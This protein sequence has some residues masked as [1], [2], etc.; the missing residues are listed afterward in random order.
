MQ[1]VTYQFYR[2]T[3]DAVQLLVHE[4]A[5]YQ[6]GQVVGLPAEQGHTT[7]ARVTAVRHSRKQPL[8]LVSLTLLTPQQ[9]DPTQ[10]TGQLVSPAGLL[11]IIHQ[12]LGR[13]HAPLTFHT[14]GGPLTTDARR[15][16]PLTWL[17]HRDS[18]AV[19]TLLPGLVATFSPYQRIIIIDPTGLYPRVDGCQT[20][21]LGPD[22]PLDLNQ[23]GWPRFTQAMAQCLP[24]TLDG[25]TL[26]YLLDGASEPGFL[27]FS[28][29]IRPLDDTAEASPGNQR[30]IQQALAQV[31]QLGLFADYP[32]QV[33]H[34]AQITHP[35][36]LQLGHLPQPW[37]SLALQ[38]VWHMLQHCPASV[39]LWIEPQRFMPDAGL[40][41]PQHTVL[42]ASA[43][44]IDGAVNQLT[45]HYGQWLLQGQVTAGF[46]VK[47]S[48]TSALP[49][50]DTRWIEPPGIQSA[51]TLTGPS[52][53]AID[54]PADDAGGQD[55]FVTPSPETPPAADNTP[56]PHPP[57][58]GEPDETYPVNVP[59]H[60]LLA[61]DWPNPEQLASPLAMEDDSPFSFALDKLDELAPLVSDAQ[62]PQFNLDDFNNTTSQPH[63]DEPDDWPDLPIPPP[64][65]TPVM[66]SPDAQDNPGT[67]ADPPD[68][69]PEE[70]AP[71][72]PTFVPAEAALPQVTESPSPSS[73][74]GHFAEGDTVR[75]P[76]YG[77]GTV[78]KVIWLD[79]DHEV[80]NVLF[81]RAG[82]RLLDPSL[83][84][85]EK[86]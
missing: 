36:V 30:V 13:I 14:H 86:V 40:T 42:V 37:R 81:D 52:P 38:H 60:T 56:D 61:D 69:E 7:Y 66:A 5:T 27:P 16:A 47:L 6:P 19:Q 79:A 76:K 23:L 29:L 48:G 31:A 25:H 77:Q 28:Q 11:G 21:T 85:L 32:G 18:D 4:P 65:T 33:F 82:K 34:P 62:L 64:Y 17:D 80:V 46:P 3:A 68:D 54:K 50:A 9:P 2:R 22:A 78:K 24:H 8:G 12:Q 49:T 10:T 35:T 72:P 67:A 84:P 39:C 74:P 70:P 73:P 75:H 15:F 55:A 1:Q 57:Q 58:M 41:S 51:D 45:R 43:Q 59:E 63:D 71:P 83:A 20:L 26:D 53:Q 44:P